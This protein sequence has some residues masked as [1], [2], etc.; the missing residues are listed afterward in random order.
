MAKVISTNAVMMK[1][2]GKT[3]L[4]ESKKVLKVKKTCISS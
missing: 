2:F 4:S 1:L 3:G